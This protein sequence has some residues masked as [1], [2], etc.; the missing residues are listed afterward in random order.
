MALL[1]HWIWCISQTLF[2]KIPY[3]DV[4]SVCLSVNMYR[5]VK[6]W[7]DCFNISKWQ[8]CTKIINELQFLAMMMVL[9]VVMFITAVIL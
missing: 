1:L 2:K 4:M 3:V 9:M 8:T 5:Q 6:Q 7:I